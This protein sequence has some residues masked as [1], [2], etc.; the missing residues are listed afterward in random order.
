M[1]NEAFYTVDEM[2]TKLKVEKR[3]IY[4]HTKSGKLPHHRIGRTIRFTNGDFEEILKQSACQA[5]K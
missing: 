5:A 3:F 1:E 4:L 2:A